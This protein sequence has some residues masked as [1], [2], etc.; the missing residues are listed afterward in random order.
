MEDVGAE[1]RFEGPRMVLESF[2]AAQRTREAAPG[3]VAARGAVELGEGRA[4]SYR[5]DVAMRDFTALETGLYAARFDGDFVIADGATVGGQ[6]LPHV[7][8]DNVEIERA[9]ILYDFAGQSETQ[10]VEASTQPLYWT[11]RIRLH[12][13]DNLRWQPPDGDIQF[14]ADLNLE[15]TPDQL[16]I[17][18]DMEAL[19]GS[20]WFLDNRFTVRRAN[21]TFDN[22][23]GVDPL[24]DAE[25]VTR[26]RPSF[27]PVAES[28]KI[29]GPYDITVR[30]QGRA[31]VPQ[32]VFESVPSDPADPILDEAQILRELTVG[33]FVEGG[34]P[35][36][37]PFESYLTRVLSRQLS[38]E[39]SRAFRGY[40]SDWEIAR[41]SGAGL[42]LGVGSQ[43]NDRLA[44]RYRQL[45]PGTAQAAPTPGATLVERDLEAEYRIN[46]FFYVTS[47]LTQKRSTAGAASVSPTPD[48]NINLK[49]R[50]EY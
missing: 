45:V 38:Q 6:T 48:F 26:L 44:L 10:Q 23:R 13:T 3:R 24:V 28:D 12:A 33:R 15:Q 39:L 1:L 42:I 37:D 46:R 50:W 16:V 41:E 47:Q 21:L 31:S 7:T 22:V 30:I 27:V 49:A 17:F 11:Y 8:S 20:Y 35:R 5:F 29:P 32:V 36:V 14:S 19:R 18:G 2:R 34:G 9:V 43:L 4:P 40:L 25:A